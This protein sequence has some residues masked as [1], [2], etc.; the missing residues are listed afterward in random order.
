MHVQHKRR[1]G[2]DRR[3]FALYY[4]YGNERRNNT[5][6]R[7]LDTVEELRPYITGS[8]SQGCGGASDR[9]VEIIKEIADAFGVPPESLQMVDSDDLVDDTEICRSC[10]DRGRRNAELEAELAENLKDLERYRNQVR[11]L[12]LFPD[13]SRPW[14]TVASVP[15]E[16]PGRQ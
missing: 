9:T 1:A 16:S 15:K 7:R 10:E 13:S 11:D 2:E 4:R 5:G 12:L 6:N 3:A 8:I 14:V